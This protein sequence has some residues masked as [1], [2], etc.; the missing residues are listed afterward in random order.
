MTNEELI[1][2]FFRERCRGDEESYGFSIKPRCSVPVRFDDQDITRKSGLTLFSKISQSPLARKISENYFIISTPSV[3]LNS[4]NWRS[5]LSLATIIAKQIG[6]GLLASPLTD[7]TKF[8]RYMESKI[9]GHL[10]DLVRTTNSSFNSLAL[11]PE[12]ILSKRY[13]DL[14]KDI[15]ILL[16]GEILLKLPRHPLA[17]LDTDEAQALWAWLIKEN[18]EKEDRELFMKMYTLSRLMAPQQKRVQGGLIPK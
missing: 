9:N 10:D 6:V 2:A 18:P 8:Q 5:H 16:E 15:R 3:A 1:R 14:V 4:N 7:E 13:Q 17:L 12:F 11:N